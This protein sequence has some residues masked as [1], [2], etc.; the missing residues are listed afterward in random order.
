[1]LGYEEAAKI[2]KQAM[3]DGATIRDTIVRLGYLRDGKLTEHQLDQALDVK[4]MTH[5]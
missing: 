1:L 5:P 2:A 4:G 3:I